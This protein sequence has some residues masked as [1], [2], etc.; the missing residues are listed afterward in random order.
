MNARSEVSFISFHAECVS[1]LLSVRHTGHTYPSPG[2]TDLLPWSS[3]PLVVF[4]PTSRPDTRPKEIREFDLNITQRLTTA[5]FFVR[6]ESNRAQTRRKPV[7]NLRVDTAAAK[8]KRREL[9]KSMIT[10]SIAL[11]PS[12]ID[13]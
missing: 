9:E 6:T 1:G 8:P 13:F 4:N 5:C 11:D 3:R 7:L 10:K 12:E 2:Q